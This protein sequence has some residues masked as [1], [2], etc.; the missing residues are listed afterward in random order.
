MRRTIKF[1]SAAGPVMSAL[2][3]QCNS[4]SQLISFKGVGHLTL[5]AQACKCYHQLTKY[6]YKEG[7]GALTYAD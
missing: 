4:T 5:S 3:E 1:T 7:D 6:P 2:P